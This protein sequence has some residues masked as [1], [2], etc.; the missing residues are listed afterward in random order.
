MANK[1]ILEKKNM[2]ISAL[3]NKNGTRI[4]QTK[5]LLKFSKVNICV[6]FQ[7]IAYP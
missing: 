7:V 2:K 6:F 1:T 4:I 5:I 3:L